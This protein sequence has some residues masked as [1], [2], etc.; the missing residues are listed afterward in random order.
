MYLKYESQSFMNFLK[1]QPVVNGAFGTG[2]SQY[3]DHD[4]CKYKYV[5]MYLCHHER[6]ECK[7]EVCTTSIHTDEIRCSKKYADVSRY[8]IST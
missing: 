2:K 1:H 7:V 8:S 5:C 3:F 4:L 6:N